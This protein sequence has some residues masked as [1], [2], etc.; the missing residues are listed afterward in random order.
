[1]TLA[2]YFPTSAKS[3]PDLLPWQ[4]PFDWIGRGSAFAGAVL[5]LQI[6][7]QE[8]GAQLDAFCIA[9]RTDIELQ[10]ARQ[11]DPTV[12]AMVDGFR[13]VTSQVQI[14]RTMAS[15][16]MRTC[17]DW[18]LWSISREHVFGRTENHAMYALP[19]Y[20]GATGA[21]NELALEVAV[22][23]V[24]AAY[25]VAHKFGGL[26]DHCTMFFEA[27]V[28]IGLKAGSGK[29]TMALTTIAAYSAARKLEA[30]QLP[31]KALLKFLEDPDTPARERAQIQVA[32]S[33][34][35][36]FYT[37][38]HPVE[39]ARRTL[40][41]LR[42]ELK[43]H[44]PLQ[45]LGVTLVDQEAWVATRAE[46]QSE[47]QALS[48]LYR[49][50]GS[51]Q[52][53]RVALDSRVLLLH[54]IIYALCK[55]GSTEDLM[56]VLHAWYAEPDSSPAD[57][58]ILFVCPNHGDGVAYVWP[59]DRHFAS[60]SA[61]ESLEK[62]LIANSNALNEYFRGPQGDRQIRVDERLK[63]T[64]AFEF[65]PEIWAAMGDHY[66]LSE[67]ADRL[68][69]GWVPRS[70]VVMPAHRD[71][72]QAMILDRLGWIAPLETSLTIS[73]DLRPIRVLSIWTG[74]THTT[75]AEVEV[76]MRVAATAGWR[77]KVT[78]GE[79]DMR[80]FRQFYE[81]SEA[82][83]LWVIGHGEQTSDDAS[84][85]GIVME[86]GTMASLADLAEFNVPRTGR[87]LLVLNIC[88]SAT[89]QTFNG[90]A[91]SGLAQE[92]VSPS[93]QVIGHLWPIDY[94]AALAFGSSLAM[95]L[96]RLPPANALKEALLMMR[97]QGELI[98]V[99]QEIS[100]DL[101]AI[102]RLNGQR[103]AEVMGNVL[104]WG[105]PVILT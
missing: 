1:M 47:I 89:A 83:V 76:L 9:L 56:T 69:R 48:K 26:D 86:D 77:A 93:Q 92:L 100:P 45:L 62:A 54:P 33:T 12:A 10:T 21:M 75:E 63:T 40:S 68:P 64:P 91:R 67:L 38:T 81:D 85:T 13:F 16:R 30:T 102:R 53:A 29:G 87:R 39:W 32:M 41:D 101:Q 11:T 36:G 80:A 8:N 3:F 7:L 31:I 103:A 42:S 73:D 28:A 97:D 14:C 74:S 25:I 2:D 96:T 50:G 17:Y 59:D 66:R 55:F 19:P 79:L 44:E 24:W 65:G 52:V 78:S 37:D 98:R 22:D 18:L 105:C 49:S 58:D 6:K 35:A 71:P 20:P 23:W 70:V 5:D 72:L 57:A 82:D 84:Q 15:G 90:M 27:A 51:R 94:Y 99:L 104:S 95:A 34:H 46:I 61:A 4:L 88:S 60:N 43:E